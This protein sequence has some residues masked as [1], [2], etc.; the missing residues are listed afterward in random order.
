MSPLVLMNDSPCPIKPT[1]ASTDPGSSGPGNPDASRPEQVCFARSV[2]PACRQPMLPSLSPAD[3]GSS[4][5][6]FDKSSWPG[7][8]VPEGETVDDPFSDFHLPPYDQAFDQYL[9]LAPPGRK[10]LQGSGIVMATTSAGRGVKR[11]KQPK[12]G[13]APKYFRIGP[14]EPRNA[15]ERRRVA[16]ITHGYEQ[17]R[18][19]LP[20]RGQLR[21]NSKLSKLQILTSAITYIKELTNLLRQ[22]ECVCDTPCCSA[23]RN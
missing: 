5:L 22:G 1:V 7:Y 14:R 11:K 21:P 4:Q 12:K 18:S 15:R 13:K 2:S 23:Y 3:P 16:T 20:E 19:R 17:L 8:V 10:K 9:G 6:V